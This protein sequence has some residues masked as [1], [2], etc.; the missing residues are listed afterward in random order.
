MLLLMVEPFVPV[1]PTP[2]SAGPVWVP[3]VCSL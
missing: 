3:D 1:P 2:R